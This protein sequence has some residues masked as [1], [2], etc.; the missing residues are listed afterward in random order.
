MIMKL[1]VTI[2]ALFIFLT[3]CLAAQNQPTGHLTIF[4]EDGDK[5]T[6]FLNGEQIN[7]KPQVNIRVE[8]L[9]Q[10]Y[11]NAK[12]VF[13]DATREAIA[14]NQVPI[15]DADGVYMDVTYK[16]RRDK[17]KA[18]KM[19]L[20]FFSVTPVVQGYVVPSNVYVRHWGRPETQQVV[21]VQQ[22]VNTGGAVT[23]TTTT[24]T[25]AG[26]GVNAGVNIDGV[27]VGI[28]VNMPANT[29]VSQTTTTT[30]TTTSGGGN[31][32]VAEPA[33]DGCVRNK[34][35]AAN[36]FTDALTTIKKISFDDTRLST[37]KQISKSNC[38]SSSQIVQICELFSFEETKLDFAKFAYDC[39]TDP[40]NY[41]NVNNIFTFSTNVE[42][43]TNYISA[44]SNR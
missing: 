27:G 22:P 2:S 3:T 39:C 19:K 35:M 25:T 9:N 16:I 1:R 4:S 24:T 10:P 7:D 14:K 41:F 12:M 33:Y 36:N 26:T 23:Q 40:K 28:S 8:D 15:T 30:S 29:T 18:T 38:L 5:F 31:V 6:L 17:N 37:A 21:V 44:K 34:P 11:Y 42:S 13:E 20:N 43:L 32:V